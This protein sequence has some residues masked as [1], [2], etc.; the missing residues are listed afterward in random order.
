V[1]QPPVQQPTR[2]R[3]AEIGAAGGAVPPIVVGAGATAA[4]AASAATAATAVKTLT[5]TIMAAFVSYLSALRQQ[6]QDWLATQLP[7]LAGTADDLQIVMADEMRREQ[8]FAKA[9]ADRVAHRLP[10]ALAIADPV[11]RKRAIEK[12]LAD[13]ERYAA[14][15]AEAMAARTLSALQRVVLKRTSPQG[16]FWKL[17]DAHKHTEGCLVMANHFWPWEVLN[18]VHP[19]RHYGCTG[20]LYGYDEAIAHGL[21]TAGDVPDLRTALRRSSGVMMEGVADA[22]LRELEIREAL[23]G[24]EGVDVVLLE[25]IELKGVANAVEP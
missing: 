7:K 9:S 4:T 24:V 11:E 10:A 14:Q 25:S 5:M 2:S 16:A 21:M 3:A 6:H 23:A 13:E 17:G 1:P 15:R 22:L 8:E 19:P 18:R 20:Q 12:I